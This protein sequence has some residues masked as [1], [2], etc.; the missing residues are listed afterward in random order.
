[1]SRV[2][3]ITLAAAFALAVCFQAALGATSYPPV[4]FNDL[5][6]RADVI[7]V[8]DVVDVRPFLLTTRTGTIIKTR[9]VFRVSDPLFGTTSSVEVFDFLGGEVGDVGMAVAEMPTFA[10]G[11]R[12]IVFAR[13]TR[14]INPIVGFRQ[15]LLRI[16]RDGSGVDRVTTLEGV[17]VAQPQDIGIRAEGPVRPLVSAM[18]LSD[19]RDRVARALAA[20]GRR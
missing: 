4:S 7:F 3:S 1:M 15:G 17:P 9:V 20:A 11:D 6:S 14:G 10:V 12:R 18:R 19:F 16:G 5:V 2:I 8:G 13:R